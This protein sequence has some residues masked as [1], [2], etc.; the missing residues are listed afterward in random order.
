MNSG[1]KRRVIDTFRSLYWKTCFGVKCNGKSSPPLLNNIGVDLLIRGGAVGWCLENIWG[2]ELILFSDT[3]EG[4][5]RQLVGLQKFCSHNKIIVNETKT[6]SMCFGT[7]EECDVYFN[8]KLIQQV[9]RYKY[10]GTIVRC[11]KRINQGIFSENSSFVCDK[12]R[13][14]IFG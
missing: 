2:D 6:K 8:G 10:L 12:S 1:W 5:Q 11:T 3:V 4:L 9:R 14:A 13:K 7:G